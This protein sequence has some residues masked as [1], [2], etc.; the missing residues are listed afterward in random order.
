MLGHEPKADFGGLTIRWAL[1]G[2]GRQGFVDTIDI[3]RSGAQAPRVTKGLLIRASLLI[4][5]AK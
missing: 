3:N 5:R 4:I 1:G 2:A